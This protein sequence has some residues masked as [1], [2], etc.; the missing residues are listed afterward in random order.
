MSRKL[1]PRKL[2]QSNAEYVLDLDS[3]ALFEAF[4]AARKLAYLAEAAANYDRTPEAIQFSDRATAISDAL[5]GK[6]L[7]RSE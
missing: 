1:S 3:Q 7:E 6:A 4:V 5:E 2:D